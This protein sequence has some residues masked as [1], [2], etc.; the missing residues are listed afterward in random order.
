MAYKV[1]F[2]DFFLEDKKFS[3]LFIFFCNLFT[4]LWKY[5]NVRYLIKEKKMNK[6]NTIKDYLI[7]GKLNMEKLVKD[8]YNYILAI[9]KNTADL[10]KEDE[11]ELI[12]DVFFII[13]KNQKSLKVDE[14]FSP[15]IAGI[16]RNIVYKKY[17]EN[18]KQRN[19]EEIK[20]NTIPVDR[21]E[22]DIEISDTNNFI[23]EQLKIL[24][25]EEYEIFTKYYYEEK[26]IKQI[27]KELNLSTSN[28]KTKL[29]RTREKLKKILKIGGF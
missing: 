13:W 9:I 22:H 8:F 7:S 12:S 3:G 15:Y 4:N 27:A 5:I 2:S 6:E 20:E 14:K 16:T 25:E 19:I 1:E 26:K 10:S 24:G 18:L 29:H 17:K 23:L 28:V 11:E 21:F